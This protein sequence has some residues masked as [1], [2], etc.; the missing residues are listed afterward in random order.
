MISNNFNSCSTERSLLAEDNSMSV[1]EDNTICC[2]D[3]MESKIAKI[4][5]VEQNESDEMCR[6]Q[7]RIA[8]RRES[9]Q[10][11]RPEKQASVLKRLEHNEAVVNATV[12]IAQR[13]AVQQSCLNLEQIAQSEQT[14]SAY[15]SQVKKIEDYAQTKYNELMEKEERL[16]KRSKLPK[17]TYKTRVRGN[18]FPNQAAGG[19]SRVL[20]NQQSSLMKIT[21]DR[22]PLFNVSKKQQCAKKY[23]SPFNHKFWQKYDM[24]HNAETTTADSSK[25]SLLVSK[26]KGRAQ[27][28]LFF[29]TPRD[30]NNSTSHMSQSHRTLNVL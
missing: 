22:I 18:R 24:L 23:T 4:L 20:K 13:K 5:A 25:A 1:I 29:D 15:T 14:C 8:I 17:F 11:E 30:V 7:S 27:S 21:Q 19:G 28:S 16:K 6:M 10:D 12:R 9:F 26:H 2:D 3:T